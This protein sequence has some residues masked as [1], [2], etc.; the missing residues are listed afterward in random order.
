MNIENQ[1]FYRNLLKTISDPFT[2]LFSKGGIMQIRKYMENMLDD[3]FKH[4]CKT[5]Q[6]IQNSEYYG[7]RGVVWS[8]TKEN[9]IVFLSHYGTIILEH[10]LHGDGFNIRGGWSATDQRAINDYL[11]YVGYYPS[12]MCKRH[13]DNLRLVVN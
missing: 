5:S 4:G 3:I 13:N 12:L 11:S 1:T 8:L 10:H 9:D 2:G 7:K 6:T